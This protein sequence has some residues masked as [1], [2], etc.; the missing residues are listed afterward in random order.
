MA[1]DPGARA[2]KVGKALLGLTEDFTREQ[3]VDRMSLYTTAFLFQA[4]GLY[5][6]SGFEFTGER[7]SPHGTELLRMLKV[8][9]KG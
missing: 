6:S 5:Q 3:R 4:I 1:V 2:Q 9:A 7:A 8:L